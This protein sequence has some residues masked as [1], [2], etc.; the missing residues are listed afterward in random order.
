MLIAI[1]LRPTKRVETNWLSNA[2]YYSIYLHTHTHSHNI[3]ANVSFT[4]SLSLADDTEQSWNQY[5]IMFCMHN[6][7]ELRRGKYFQMSNANCTFPTEIE[8]AHCRKSRKISEDF[9]SENWFLDDIFQLRFK[10]FCASIFENAEP[11]T[12]SRDTW[13]Q[14]KSY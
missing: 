12:K 6:R 13:L 3:T 5:M 1:R 11:H 10:F 2:F 14:L 8:I 7:I 9:M 4:R